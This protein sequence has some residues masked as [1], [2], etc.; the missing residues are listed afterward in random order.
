MSLVEIN[1]E[2]G[3]WHQ[4]RQHFA[5]HHFDILGDSHHGDFTLNKIV[6]EITGLK[7]LYLHASRIEFLHPVLKEKVVFEVEVPM[8]FNEVLQ[9][10][11][12]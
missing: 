3:R 2:T 10:V 1:P 8:E 9:K 5:Q 11:M 6:T 7:R 4:L 12:D